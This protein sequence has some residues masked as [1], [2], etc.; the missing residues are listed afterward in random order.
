MFFFFS[1][2]QSCNA[3]IVI[4]R[5]DFSLRVNDFLCYH[6]FVF[7]KILLILNQIYFIS[8]NALK[9]RFHFPNLKNGTK[10]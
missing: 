9:R 7:V 10:Y 4:A 3:I 6:A 5:R 8:I 1:N 2:V